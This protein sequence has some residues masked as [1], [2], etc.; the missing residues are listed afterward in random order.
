MAVFPN[1]FESLKCRAKLCIL[2][3]WL[4]DHKGILN[5]YS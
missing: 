2:A 3:G 5:V 4:V 1:K